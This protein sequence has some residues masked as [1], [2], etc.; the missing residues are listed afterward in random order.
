[1]AAAAVAEG[2]MPFE[3]H[4]PQ[5]IGSGR[6][7]ALPRSRRAAVAWVEPAV[8]AQ[9][10]GDGAGTGRMG[11]A[12][13]QEAIADLAPTPRRIGVAHIENG[14][15]EV[16]RGSPRAVMGTTRTVLQRHH[17]PFQPAADPLVARLGT[18]GEVSAH[19]PD[20]RSIPQSQGHQLPS[21]RHGT[22]LPP[23]HDRLLPTEG[24]PPA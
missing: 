21:Q 19:L 16:G 22:C 24:S 13:G 17:A 12:Y 2:E 10:L 20:V 18:D 9:D 5:G 8:T 4:L 23:G 1:M 14:S 15:L 11:H 3:V 7:E 6:L